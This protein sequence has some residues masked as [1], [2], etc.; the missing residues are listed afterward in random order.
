MRSGVVY[1]ILLLL[2]TENEV[3]IPGLGTLTRYNRAARIDSEETR[4]IPPS[5]TIRFAHDISASDSLLETFISHKTGLDEALSAAHVSE[6]TQEV[7]KNLDDTGRVAIDSFGVFY[8]RESDIL[9]TPEQFAANL[10]YLGL[11]EVPIPHVAVPEESPSLVEPAAEVVV[12]PIVEAASAVEATTP[13]PPAHQ[14]VV[15]PKKKRRRIPALV[16]VMLLVFALVSVWAILSY[17]VSERDKYPSSVYNRAPEMEEATVIP[18][19]DDTATDTGLDSAK[20]ERTTMNGALLDIIDQEEVV[21]E[22]E[23]VD[24]TIE[25][26]EEPQAAIGTSIDTQAAVQTPEQAEDLPAEPDTLEVSPALSE[27][28]SE[29]TSDSPTQSTTSTVADGC[30][31]IVGA[32]GV[33]SNVDRMVRRLEGLGYSTATMPRGALTQVGVPADCESQEIS[34]VLEEL[35][36]SVEAQ[37]WIFKK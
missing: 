36:V 29:N 28:F 24:S 21:S 33:A 19:T 18:T 34:R 17:T 6:F 10:A 7:Q 20:E 2:D 1:Y 3:V 35:K 31:V 14:E 25:E 4:V 23:A 37:A 26:I 15:T 22:D 9:F 30:Y 16:P 27:T 8:Q 5:S 12:V 11:K 32:F 13:L